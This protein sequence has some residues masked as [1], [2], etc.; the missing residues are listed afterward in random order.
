MPV[1]LELA[2]KTKRANGEP[3]CEPVVYPDVQREHAAPREAVAPHA[4]IPRRPPGVEA[5]T[6]RAANADLRALMRAAGVR[7]AAAHA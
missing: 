1:D 7:A 6:A 3:C 2:P 4:R 5:R